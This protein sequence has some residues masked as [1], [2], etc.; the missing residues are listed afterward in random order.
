MGVLVEDF[1]ERLPC[2]A[3][4]FF[5]QRCFGEIRTVAD[6]VFTTRLPPP[7]HTVWWEGIVD[8]TPLFDPAVGGG[9]VFRYVM[10]R[11]LQS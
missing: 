8:S 5:S 9:G 7:P 3:T 6:G 1:Q 10:P 4:G 11:V 2:R